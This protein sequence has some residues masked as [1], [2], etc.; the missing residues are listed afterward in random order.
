MQNVDALLNC[1]VI[2]L[3]GLNIGFFRWLSKPKVAIYCDLIRFNVGLG[4]FVC[5]GWLRLISFYT[6]TRTSS[7]NTISIQIINIIDIVIA[8]V[9]A[10]S[11]RKFSVYVEIDFRCCALNYIQLFSLCVRLD[12]FF[13][14]NRPLAH[15]SRVYSINCVQIHTLC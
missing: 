3:F 5:N 7:H 8:I 2:S 6:H 15:S 9:L 1:S 12:V 13:S 10:N 11:G 14:H 4:V